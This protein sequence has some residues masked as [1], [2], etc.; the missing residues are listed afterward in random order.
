[1]SDA[2]RFE[3]AKKLES[4]EV[5]EWIK[6]PAIKY[7][8]EIYLGPIGDDHNDVAELV[9]HARSEF[10]LEDEKS[11]R[12]GFM[13]SHGRFVDREEAT[14]IALRTNQVKDILRLRGRDPFIIGARDLTYPAE[15][16]R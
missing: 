8:G 5:P 2:G 6:G 9:S 3:K 11:Y 7:R 16:D 10:R 12:R 13:T 4:Q 15:I 1:M 14:E